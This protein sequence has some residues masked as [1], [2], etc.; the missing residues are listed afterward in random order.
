M[1]RAMGFIAEDPV[2]YIQLSISRIPSYFMFWPSS[3][4]STLSNISRVLSFG[5]AVPF[6]IVGLWISLKRWK[7]NFTAP[8]T[9][10]YLFMGFYISIHLL[11]WALVRYRLPVDAVF[12]LFSSLAMVRLLEPYADRFKFQSKLAVEASN[13]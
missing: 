1:D 4:S 6:I 3:Q 7:F 8:E 10:L 11:S 12:L 5:V 2:R 13:S 9:L